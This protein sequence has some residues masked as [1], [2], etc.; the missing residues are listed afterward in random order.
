[1]N[2]LNGITSTLTLGRNREAVNKRIIP[3]LG[4]LPGS[5]V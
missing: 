2:V 3:P 5:L 1:M 4:R